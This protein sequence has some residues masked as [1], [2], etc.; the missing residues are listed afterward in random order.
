MR[1]GTTTGPDTVIGFAAYARSVL[2]EMRSFV[3]PLRAMGFSGQIILGTRRDL[4]NAEWELLERLDVT[5]Y[6]IDLVP[7]DLPWM[8]AADSTRD[9]GLSDSERI[10]S[11]CVAKYP[12]LKMEWARFQLGSDWL[13]ECDRC[14]GWA[15]LTDFRDVVFQ[16]PDPFRLLDGLQQGGQY[17]LFLVEEWAGQP[18]GL[19]NNHWF[20]WSSL[21]NCYGSERGDAIV[22]PYRS[23][24]VVCS[25]TVMG[26]RDGIAH[27]ADVITAEFY[28]LVE[29]GEHC[30]APSVVDQ[31]IH[32]QLWYQGRFGPNATAIAYGAGPV[33]TVGAACANATHHSLTE[34]LRTDAA[35]YVVNSDGQRAPIVH[36]YDRC[37]DTFAARV[38]DLDTFVAGL[39]SV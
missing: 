35:G 14:T 21:Y 9:F 8:T 10:R 16:R 20:S 15:L 12:K 26:N 33:L 7:C 11:V 6:A 22:Q 30:V 1:R 17:N 37:H 3:E 23:K 28:A 31:A 27:Y 13:Q 5:V 25:G 39:E 38:R 18:H 4:S 34:V 2:V 29:Q 36:Q 32:I 24:P 19:T